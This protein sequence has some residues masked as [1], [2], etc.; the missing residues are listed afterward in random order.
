MGTLKED[1]LKLLKRK[2]KGCITEF[3]GRSEGVQL[4]TG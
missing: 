3:W 1:G 4:L 2:S